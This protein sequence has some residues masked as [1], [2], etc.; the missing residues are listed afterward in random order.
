MCYVTVLYGPCRPTLA[1]CR[2]VSTLARQMTRSRK[3]VIALAVSLANEC[4]H[5]A[6]IHC[7][8]GP[9]AGSD[10]V[11]DE[12]QS[13]YQTR[14]AEA[15]FSYAADENP[16]NRKLATWGLKHRDGSARQRNLPCSVSPRLFFLVVV[17]LHRLCSLFHERRFW[18][19]SMTECELEQIPLWDKAS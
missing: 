1:D 15:S 9:A 10:V 5:C 6:F 11:M 14:D 19:D 3:E 16:V 12:M 17:T 2:C 8:M 13:F 18:R 7:A 4:P